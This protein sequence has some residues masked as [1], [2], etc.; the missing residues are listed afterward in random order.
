LVPFK[1]SLQLSNVACYNHLLFISYRHV[2]ILFG[3]TAILGGRSSNLAE[4]KMRGPEIDEAEL[5]EGLWHV[6]GQCE[7]YLHSGEMKEEFELKGMGYP[8]DQWIQNEFR[9]RSFFDSKTLTCSEVIWHTRALSNR[10][11]TD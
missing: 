11:A 1:K 9:T 10:E 8:L 6:H 7:T 5:I 3:A 2:K 4:R